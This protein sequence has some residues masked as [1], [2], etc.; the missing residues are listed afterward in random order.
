MN[1]ADEA[2]EV[3]ALAERLTALPFPEAETLATSVVDRYHAPGR[4][5]AD[6]RS[7]RR[8]GRR[9]LLQATA[10]LAALVV[11]VLVA[12]AMSPAIGNAPVI[13]PV[14]A[15]LL[16]I[17]GLSPAK[18][19]AVVPLIGGSTSANR[20][21]SLVAGYADS[22][23]TLVIVNVSSDLQPMDPTLTDASGTV[24][25]SNGSIGGGK[26]HLILDF[27]PL[28]S[29]RPDG[30]PLTLH[31]S[32][33]LDYRSG[34]G[35]DGKGRQVIG[36]WTLRFSL[37]YESNGLP[38]PASG[39]L[40]R[41]TV[42]FTAVAA[43]SGSIHLRFVTA[44]A[45]MD[46]LFELRTVPCAKGFACV[47]EPAGTPGPTPFRYQLLDP[48]GHPMADMVN[49]N[50]GGKGDARA[51]QDTTIGWDTLYSQAGPGRYRI[52]MTWDGSRIER[53]IQVP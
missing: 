25:R 49:S 44:G 7:M 46:E 16:G 24:L 3:R 2:P 32:R 15:S 41:V 10:A 37:P 53:D 9:R 21:I 36:D 30:N 19:P 18:D 48:S 34:K 13:N 47:P 42:T 12:S 52:V 6:R 26:D 45:T 22:T 33:M 1:M 29:P 50:E 23:R 35:A 27:G 39:R 8:P 28:S 51:A 4:A 38:V 31:V 20:T 14:A 5:G 40:G 11:T 43:S 17:L